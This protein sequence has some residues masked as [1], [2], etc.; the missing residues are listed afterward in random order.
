MQTVAAQEPARTAEA[1][2]SPTLLYEAANSVRQELRG[3][4]DALVSQ[5]HGYLRELE[6]HDVPGPARSGMEQRIVQIDARIAETDKLIIAA[7]A[8]VAK[9]A[10]I[11]GAVTVQP[12][13]D[14][15]GP[16]EEMF[17]I[18]PFVVLVLLLPVSIAIAR[19]VWKR[20][21]T[22][23]A[24]FPREVMERLSRLEQMG[25][26]TSLEIER[27]GEGQRFV[28]RLLTE[29]PDRIGAGIGDAREP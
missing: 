24:E 1:T 26:A 27:I 17:F 18:A 28:T 2:P 23:I 11:P 29:R 21:T 5:R 8:Q 12:R 10:A 22:R 16:P 7:D 6:D 19:R 9:A 4:L 20:G 14:W 13:E 3:Q 25:E 15:N